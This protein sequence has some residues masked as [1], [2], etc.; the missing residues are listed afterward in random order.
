MPDTEPRKLRSSFLLRLK[1]GSNGSPLI[2]EQIDWPRTCSVL[3]GSRMLRDGPEPENCT[4]PAAP[5]SSN[6]RPAPRV[7]SK[8]VKAK[9]LP[10]T[11]LRASSADIGPAITGAAIEAAKTA[12]N[13][14]RATI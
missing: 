13:T 3:T 12:P 11:N 5:P 8:Q 6:T 4:A 1:H 7:P 10:A 2:E 14:K 9:T